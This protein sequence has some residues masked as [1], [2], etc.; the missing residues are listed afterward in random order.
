MYFVDA[1][2]SRI[3]MQLLDNATTL[4]DYITENQANEGI[5]IL[6]AM[7][8]AQVAQRHSSVCWRRL[9]RCWYVSFLLS[10]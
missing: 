5:S 8:V 7:C 9:A 10:Q 4:K 1:E 3:Y 2:K 6:I